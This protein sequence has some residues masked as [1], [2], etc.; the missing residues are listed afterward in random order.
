MGERTFSDVSDSSQSLWQVSSR[1]E[2]LFL[3]THDRISLVPSQM[4][5]GLDCPEAWYFTSPESIFYT[6]GSSF[7]ARGRGMQCPA[8]ACSAVIEGA[9]P[10]FDCP[11]E[12]MQVRVG[13]GQNNLVEGQLDWH[14]ESALISKAGREFI[15]FG[16]QKSA[17][18]NGLSLRSGRWSPLHLSC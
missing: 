17:G 8:R 16:G 6:L 10:S 5:L 7:K 15:E 4:S 2:Q 14:T 9:C 13:L 11:I 1:S 12:E 18:S 3:S